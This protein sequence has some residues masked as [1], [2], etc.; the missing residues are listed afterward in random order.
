MLS[1]PAARLPFHLR[2][3]FL[4]GPSLSV[5]LWVHLGGLE[6]G[7][8]RGCSLRAAWIGQNFFENGVLSQNLP[9][10]SHRERQTGGVFCS[11]KS[12]RTLRGHHPQ[13]ITTSCRTS[14]DWA[15]RDRRGQEKP[16]PFSCASR[17]RPSLPGG[18]FPES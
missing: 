10:A 8:G 18:L 17:P 9:V 7:E 6:E 15:G 5:C 3:S 11:G 1:P 14:R 4:P 2:S 16:F 12:P 13:G